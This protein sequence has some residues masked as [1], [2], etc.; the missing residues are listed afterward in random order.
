MARARLRTSGSP[1]HHAAP[2]LLARRLP[3]YDRPSLRYES[4]ARLPRGKRRARLTR[5]R[6]RAIVAGDRFRAPSA[7]GETTVDRVGSISGRFLTLVRESLFRRGATERSEQERQAGERRTLE[8]ATR[9]INAD[10]LKSLACSIGENTILLIP[11][12]LS[13]RYAAQDFWNVGHVLSIF[14]P[15]PN[16]LAYDEQ[17]PILG[18]PPFA[19]AVCRLLSELSERAPHRFRE[20]LTH[21]PM[22]VYDPA[23]RSERTDGRT[24]GRFAVDGRDYDRLRL[25]FLR[26]AGHNVAG[27]VRNNWSEGAAD[28]Y[29]RAVVADLSSGALREA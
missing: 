3:I 28:E 25:A 12:D 7:E 13:G 14:A 15:W 19:A 2:V 8:L 16:E 10:Q 9:T 6:G 1:R 18:P 4:S 17:F 20:A 5:R 27:K 22:A 21:L 24:D 11:R 23:I 26:E 29:V